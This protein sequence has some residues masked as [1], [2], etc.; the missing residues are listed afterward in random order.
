MATWTR[1]GARILLLAS[2][3]AVLGRA[4]VPAAA[5]G[6]D[7]H[8]G[9]PAQRTL[10][11]WAL[12]Q[13][14][15]AG[16]ELPAVDVW[17]HADPEDCGGGNSGFYAGGRLDICVTEITP[18]ARNVIVHELA[19]AWQ[20]LNLDEAD[21]RR[22]LQLRNLTTWNSW[23]VPW[24]FRGT[25]QAAEILTWGVG[26]RAIPPLLEGDDDPEQLRAA[27]EMLTGSLPPDRVPPGP[28][29]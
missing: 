28:G 5:R 14:H 13:Y 11:E 2:I 18:Y 12:G 16:L 22:F 15:T 6:T 19:H 7:V 17:F 3:A 21:E 24:A 10:V 20:D 1:I 25:E 27:Y 23:D 8:G 4:G 29:A 9:T 26:D